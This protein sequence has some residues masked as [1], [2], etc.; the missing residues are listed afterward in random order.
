M[1]VKT[2]NYKPLHAQV[3][4]LPVPSQVPLSSA[5]GISFSIL[6]F[7][8]AARNLLFPHS[9]E[10]IINNFIRHCTSKQ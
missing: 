2:L 6:R 4:M 8:F 1:F 7:G 5:P 3:A 9:H 10:L